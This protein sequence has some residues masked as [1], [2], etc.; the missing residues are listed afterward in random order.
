MEGLTDIDLYLWIWL[1]SEKKKDINLRFSECSPG[2]AEIVSE[3]KS[4]PPKQTK[5]SSE[6]VWYTLIYLLSF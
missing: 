5:P 6:N 3:T 2:Q 1:F 4:M